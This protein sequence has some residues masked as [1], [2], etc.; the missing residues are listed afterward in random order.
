MLGA[1]LSIALLT[2]AT[3]QDPTPQP[4]F[5]V[6]CGTLYPGDGPAMHD[7][8]LVVKDGR[9]DAIVEDQAPADMRILDAS[10]KVVM[11]G[12]VAADSF[13]SGQRDTNYNV[14]PDFVAIDGFDFDREFNSA[15]SG[16]VT[17]VYLGNGRNRLVSGQGSV[18]KLFGDDLIGRTLSESCALQITLGAESTRSPA[19]F[20][21]TL[22]PSDTAPLGPARQ[23]FPTARISQLTVL[24]DLF[25][26]ASRGERTTDS[27]MVENRYDPEAL[28]QAAAGNLPLRIAAREAADVIRALQLAKRM[29]VQLTLENPFEVERIAGRIARAG[30]NVVVRVPVALSSVNRGGEDRLSKAVRNDPANAARVADA[31]VTFALAPDRDADLADFLFVAGIAIRHGLD[32]E[33]AMRAITADAAKT[34]GVDGRVGSLRPG[35]DADFLVLSGEPFSVGTLVE[36]TFVEGRPA[37]ERQQKS[38]ML[39]IRASRVLTSAGPVLRDATVIIDGHTIKAVGEEL[40]VPYGARVVD[41]G[42][43]VITPGF[44][45]AFTSAGLSG[46]GVGVPTGT[47]SQRI[48]D[49]VQH[50]DPVFES[51]RAAGLTTVL[52]AGSDGQAISGR[53]AAIK[54]GAADDESA[55][56][57]DIAALRIVHDTIGSDSTKP[58]ADLISRGKRYIDSWKKY[59]KALADWEAGKLKAAEEAATTPAEPDENDPVTGTWECELSGLPMPIPITL[60]L[61]L[62][63]EGKKVTGTVQPSIGGNKIPDKGTLE[64]ATFENGKLTGKVD[65][66][67]DKADFEATIENDRLEGT[68]SMMGQD[69]TVDGERV[70]ASDAD[71]DDLEDDKPKAPRVDQSL[72]PVRAWIEKKI[73]LVIRSNRAPAVKAVLEFFEQQK[74]EDRLHFVM[75]GVEDALDTP[76]ILGDAPPPIVLGPTLVKREKGELVNAAARLADLGA[77]LAFGTGDTDGAR[78]LPLHVAHAIRWGLDPEAALRA[79]TIDAARMFKLDERVGSLERGKDADL[80]VFSGNPFELTS[81]VMLVVCNG[82]IVYDARSE[83]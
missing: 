32:P 29:G 30:A 67:G 57:K 20:E 48:A 53:V 28:R 55:V 11:P 66:M 9:I 52:V 21:P 43:A 7:V 47:A 50:D 36:K 13:L 63:L 16:G 45:N 23:Q 68:I 24:R 4:T 39:A 73:P 54:T 44:I 41:L 42:D 76:D 2:G 5:A 37:F 58:L 78:Y 69:V 79:L 33:A 26:A 35:R 8:W 80:V 10:D 71:D 12:I 17:T 14:T 75:A 40:A 83:R 19:L 27:I 74:D 82:R 51:A 15:L 65:M 59:E 64:D 3:P 77:P 22:N 46:D 6:H 60:E 31:G 49:I 70:E 72:E 1:L 18:V 61:V 56:L 34:L 62:K 38:N 25:D 81:H